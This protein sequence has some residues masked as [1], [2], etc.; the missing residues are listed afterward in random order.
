[1]KPGVLNLRSVTDAMPLACSAAPVEAEIDS[2][3]ETR[4]SERRCAVTT[5]SW[6]PPLSCAAAGAGAVAC[7]AAAASLPVWG[8]GVPCAATAEA[9]TED[10]PASSQRMA[11][12]CIKQHSLKIIFFA[13]S[14]RLGCVPAE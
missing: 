10:V 8:G 6:T 5:M 11:R 7:D 1:M 9:R 3:T 4:F 12:V 2:G 13:W 14:A